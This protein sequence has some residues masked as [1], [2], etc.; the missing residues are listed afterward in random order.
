[1]RSIA[2]SLALAILFIVPT[3][4]A[5]SLPPAD[6]QIWSTYENERFGVTAE[7]P[8]VGFF[9]QDDPEN[10]DGVLLLDATGEI[11]IRVFGNYWNTLSPTFSAYWSERREYLMREGAQITYRPGGPGWFVFSG[12]LGRQIFY[13]KATTRQDCSVAG[14]I[15]FLFPAD[16]RDAVS[17]IIER[18]EDSLKLGPSPDCP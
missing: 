4:F 3:A 11:E 17:P 18:M 10:G 8:T 2:V 6:Q 5:Q 16:Q 1:M 15:Y 14:H 13:F 12:Y 9:Q 7:V